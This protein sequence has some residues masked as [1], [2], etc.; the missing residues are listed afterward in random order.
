MDELLAAGKATGND[1]SPAMLN[2]TELN[3]TRMRRLEKRDRLT[4]E[5]RAAL[6]HMDRPMVWLTI[7]EGWCGDAAQILPVIEQVAQALPAVEHRLVLRDEHLELMDAFLTNGARSIPIT[8]ILDANSQEVLGSWGPRP[9]ELQGMVMDAKTRALAAEDEATR[10]D[11]NAQAK[12]DTQK[13]YAR[14]KTKAVQQ[15]F[16][17]T[18]KIAVMQQA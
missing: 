15:E 16:L 1:H 3:V 4:E 18:L 2:Y 9:E 13:W 7:T 14:D 6:Q 8:I 5:T 17:Q 12:I 11:I 10:K